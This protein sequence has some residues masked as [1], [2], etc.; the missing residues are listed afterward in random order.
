MEGTNGAW[1]K[2]AI[3]LKRSRKYTAGVRKGKAYLYSETHPGLAS[4]PDLETTT[5]LETLGGNRVS[6]DADADA[7]AETET[8][9]RIHLHHLCT[10]R[11]DDDD[12]DGIDGRCNN[13][14]R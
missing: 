7:N 3:F 6:R 2:D 13:Q 14:H 11:E 4:L 1:R 10:R 8:R 12:D 5:N 9:I